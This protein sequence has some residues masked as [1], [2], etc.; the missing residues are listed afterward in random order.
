LRKNRIKKGKLTLLDKN[1][2]GVGGL[3]GWIGGAPKL[4]KCVC[5]RERDRE[6]EDV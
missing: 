1:Y 6:R 5:V 2:I 3:G 4:I